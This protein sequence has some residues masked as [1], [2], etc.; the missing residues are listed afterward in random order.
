MCSDSHLCA[1]FG[2]F[3]VVALVVAEAGVF[4]VVELIE[5]VAVVFVD[6]AVGQRP[7]YR[8]AFDPAVDP[9]PEPQQRR[10]I[11]STTWALE[12]RL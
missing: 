9:D 1:H 3:D 2:Q 8:P 7:G 4:P 10:P 6:P 12:Q 5:P 11:R